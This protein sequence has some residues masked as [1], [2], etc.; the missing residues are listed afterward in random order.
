[1]NQL[2][3]SHWSTPAA[4]CAINIAKLRTLVQKW[5]FG[6]EQSKPDFQF[7]DSHTVVLLVNMALGSLGPNSYMHLSGVCTVCCQSV[8]NHHHHHDAKRSAVASRRCDLPPKRSVPSQLKSIS[9]RY[10]CVPVDLMDPCGERSA[11]S[12]PPVW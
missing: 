4:S 5:I 6:L 3:T 11:S 7:W 1:M 2:V 12:A 10:S 9:H 8:V